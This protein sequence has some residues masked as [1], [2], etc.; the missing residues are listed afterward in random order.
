MFVQRRSGYKVACKDCQCVNNAS[1]AR[2]QGAVVSTIN[3]A[4]QAARYH[5][6]ATINT[7]AIVSAAS[8]DH[9][10]ALI[11]LLKSL[12]LS[13]P[14]TPVLVWDLSYPAPKINM[15]DLRAVHST[16]VALRHFN[17]DNYPKH[18]DIHKSGGQWA[19][20]PVLIKE[21]LEEYETVLWMDSGNLAMSGRFTASK[22]LKA[23]GSTGFFS[24]VSRGS[25]WQWSHGGMMQYFGFI[26]CCER[27]E[28]NGMDS[29]CCC[30]QSDNRT[31]IASANGM[32]PGKSNIPDNAGLPSSGRSVAVAN[33]ASERKCVWGVGQRATGSGRLGC[34]PLPAHVHGAYDGVHLQEVRFANWKQKRICNG[35]LVAFRR[36]S[37]AYTKILLP[38]LACAMEPACISPRGSNRVNHRQ[39]W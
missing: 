21:A 9:L 3:A 29:C 22:I 36:H 12:E 23:T 20:K 17:F 28:T 16:V 7:T 6:D 13:A 5:G 34:K 24:A 35:A 15:S 8:E 33:V 14:G 38:W 18:F 31:T 27:Q 1:Q 39:V 25:L 26:K 10:C 4:A 19:W 30:T 37:P 11:N 32:P 2:A